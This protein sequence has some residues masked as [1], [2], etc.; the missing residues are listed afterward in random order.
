MSRARQRRSSGTDPAAAFGLDAARYAAWIAYLFDRPE[1][2]NGWYFDEP[3]DIGFEADA[4]E[5]VSLIGC[6]MAR[7]GTDLAGFS[8][9]QTYCGLNYMVSELFDQGRCF[10]DPSVSMATRV[11]AI[12]G[13]R[14]LYADCLSVRCAPVLGHLSETGGTPLNGFAYMLWDTSPIFHLNA[15]AP[16]AVAA[17][18]AVLERALASPNVACIESALHGLGHRVRALPNVVQP[19]IA[20]FLASSFDAGTK[21]PSGEAWR[22][23][24][25]ELRAYAERAMAGSIL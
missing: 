8:D 10:G 9:A 11:A 2:P 13:F 3:G 24:R 19:V 21:P 23:L 14:K 7:S 5:T 22:P 1:T 4:R 6:T 15:H 17:I 12:G 25:R 16:E 20:R 18:V